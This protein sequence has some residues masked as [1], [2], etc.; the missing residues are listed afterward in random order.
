MK[1]AKEQCKNSSDSNYGQCI[2]ERIRGARPKIQ[3]AVEE[4]LPYWKRLENLRKSHRKDK[5]KDK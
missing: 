3:E 4:G 5:A 1:V 2:A